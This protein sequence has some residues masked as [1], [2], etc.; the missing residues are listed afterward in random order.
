MYISCQ[1]CM[2]CCLFKSP[3]TKKNPLLTTC[4]LF[5][6]HWINLNKAECSW[7]Q[8]LMND[9][10]GWLAGT[11]KKVEQERAIFFHIFKAWTWSSWKAHAFDV[12]RSSQ[13]SAQNGIISPASP[14]CISL[15]FEQPSLVDLPL[16]FPKSLT[17][18]FGNKTWKHS[19]F[20]LVLGRIGR[21]SL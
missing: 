20:V 3:F 14:W 19:S 5:L 2:S 7:I 9:F 15:W 12:E 18:V 6:N 11:L 21:G 1:F 16:N 10:H 17:S 4:N 8:K 13:W